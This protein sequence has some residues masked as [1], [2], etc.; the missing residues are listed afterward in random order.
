MQSEIINCNNNKN[1]DYFVT[2]NKE[3][4]PM[5]TLTVYHIV[6]K[7]HIYQGSTNIGT[8]TFERNHVSHKNFF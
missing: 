5:S 4:M 7:S 8:K 1:C 2:I 6:D 3:M